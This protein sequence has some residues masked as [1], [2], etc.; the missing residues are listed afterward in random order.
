M[1]TLSLIGCILGSVV[2]VS[3]ALDAAEETVAAQKYVGSYGSSPSPSGEMIALSGIALGEVGP[4]FRMRLR[5][6]LVHVR[7]PSVEE[8]LTWVEGDC[9]VVWAPGNVLI[10]CGTPDDIN[11][12]AIHII[13][14]YECDPY[15]KGMATM[16]IPSEAEKVLADCRFPS[17]GALPMPV[18]GPSAKPW[19]KPTAPCTPSNAAAANSPRTP[20]GDLNSGRTRVRPPIPFA[21]P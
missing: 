21:P 20:P 18:S 4:S 11:N 9:V 1:K 7:G 12:P 14:A 16:R 17:V 2:W 6:L 10:V 3:A 5:V 8:I 15:G 19:M 13:L